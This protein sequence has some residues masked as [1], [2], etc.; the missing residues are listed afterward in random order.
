[1]DKYTLTVEAI[2]SGTPSLTAQAPVIITVT[3]ANENRPL[4]TR[5]SYTFHVTEQSKVTT[6]VGVFVFTISALLHYTRLF[7]F[8]VHK[9][10][11][12][13]VKFACNYLMKSTRTFFIIMYGW[14]VL[15]TSP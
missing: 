4:F 11:C 13:R 2:D 3:D 6:L 8:I 7:V 12:T 1:M 15:V 14:T 9:H 10:L 5:R